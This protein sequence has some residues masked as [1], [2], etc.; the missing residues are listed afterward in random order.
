MK[1]IAKK[2]RFII[3]TLSCLT[4]MSCMSKQMYRLGFENP[5]TGYIE[6]GKWQSDSTL[7]KAWVD[8]ENEKY[9]EFIHWVDV[10]K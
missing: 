4:F 10:K 3:Y 9:P 8:Y 1:R 6:Y 7:V 5:N 2:I